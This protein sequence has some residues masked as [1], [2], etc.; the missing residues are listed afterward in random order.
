MSALTLFWTDKGAGMAKAK[1][2]EP[3][4]LLEF[5]VCDVDR[6]GY[7]S[8]HADVR[9][10][11]P[12]QKAAMQMLTIELIRQQATVS[13]LSGPIRVNSPARAIMWL[14]E[15]VADGAENSGAQFPKLR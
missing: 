15:R 7:A 8:E 5:P 9:C 11:N 2:I 6:A 4:G 3:V 12:R 14:L 13:G 10:S 1:G